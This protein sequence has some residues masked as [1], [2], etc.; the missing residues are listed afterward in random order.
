MKQNGH[1]HLT[2][3]TPR[4]V[5]SGISDPGRVRAENEDAIFIDRGGSF[6]LLADGMGGHERGAEASSKAL[7]VIQEFLQP[8]VLFA[9]LQDVTMVEGVPPEVICLYA[10]ID[11]AVSKANSDIFELN[12]KANLKR[13]M[14]TTVVGLVR[15]E[16]DFMLW[17]HVGDSRLYRWRDSM[18]KCLT[19]DHSAHAEWVKNG[20]HGPEPRKNIITRAIGPFPSTSVEIKWEKWLQGDVYILCSDGLTDMLM[21]E[22]IVQILNS[23]KNVDDIASRLIH[24]ANDA[25]GKDNTSVVVCRV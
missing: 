19:L 20:M 9:K 22:K 6:M 1:I 18:L 2:V 8:K 16:G 4:I 24:A 21:D 11:D 3:E 5:I 25:G 13:Y 12:Q 23:E 15:V 10:L 7:E 17:F 14:G